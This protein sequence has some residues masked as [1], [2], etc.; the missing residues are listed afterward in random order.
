[1]RTPVRL[2]HHVVLLSA[3]NSETRAAREI[4]DRRQITYAEVNG[5]PHSAAPRLPRPSL[6]VYG[7]VYRGLEGIKRAIN[8]DPRL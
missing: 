3:D 4:L 5:H 2:S 7:S 6:L 1:M 8:L